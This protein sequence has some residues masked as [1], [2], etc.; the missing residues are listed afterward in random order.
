MTEG[1]DTAISFGQRHRMSV[2]DIPRMKPTF[3]CTFLLIE[4]LGLTLLPSTLI[5]GSEV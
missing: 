1:R 3:M 5:I 4:S 2:P